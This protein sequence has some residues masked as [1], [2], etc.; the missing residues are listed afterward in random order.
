MTIFLLVEDS[1]I[2]GYT[3]TIGE[4]EEIINNRIRDY[5]ADAELLSRYHLHDFKE[6]N[7]LWTVRGTSKV[8]CT[9][10]DTLLKSFEIRLVN[11]LTLDSD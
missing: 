8:G 7:T 1:H 11:Q 3:L 10:S 9:F 4:G 5:K 6:T 2:V